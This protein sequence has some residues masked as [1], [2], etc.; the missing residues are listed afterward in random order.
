[1]ITGLDH[2]AVAVRDFDAAVDGYRRLFA[3]EPDLEPGQGARR[4]WF[5]F[6]NAAL[7]VIAA[8]GEG[9]AGDRVRARLDEAGE[10]IWVLSFTVGDVA[11]ATR[12]LERRG[13]DVEAVAGVALVKAAGLSFTLREARDAPPSSATGEGPVDALDHVVVY[14][15]NPDRALALFGAKLD[16]DLRLDRAN[17]QWGARQLFFR[18]GGA[19]VEVGA[20]LKTPVSDDPDRFGGLA[21]QVTDPDAARA[22]MAAEGFDVSEVRTGRKPGTRVFT[23]RDAP[24][25]VPTLML[26]PT[27]QAGVA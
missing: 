6:P 27:Q 14:T 19:V 12:L 3:R 24:G 7:E 11:A 17:S 1:M 10:G 20:S 16:L 9:V 4:A 22:R 18:C 21:W 15:A 25:G 2:V 8:D 5:R 23:V 13:L 26:Q